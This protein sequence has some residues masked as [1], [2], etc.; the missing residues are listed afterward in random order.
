[1]QSDRVLALL[2]AL[3]YST[4]EF[5]VG[6]GESVNESI[7]TAFKDVQRYPLVV[8][9][10]DA[11]KNSNGQTIGGDW[12]VESQRHHN[13]GIISAIAEQII[14]NVFGRKKPRFW[15]QSGVQD[16]KDRFL[17]QIFMQAFTQIQTAVS[18]Q[19]ALS[20]RPYVNN[21]HIYIY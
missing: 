5:S 20:K 8:K 17:L 7:F 21:A 6:R 16:E 18:K 4:V 3:G 2:K 11:S 1:M 10:L 13:N 19:L 9:I 14:I 12:E 15:M